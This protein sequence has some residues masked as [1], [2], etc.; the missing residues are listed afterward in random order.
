MRMIER[1]ASFSACSTAVHGDARNRAVENRHPWLAPQLPGAPQLT[2][3]DYRESR[4]RISYQPHSRIAAGEVDERFGTVLIM[5]HPPT[6]S[7]CRSSPLAL[8]LPILTDRGDVYGS[9]GPDG[10]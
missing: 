10:N 9:Q 8:R 1:K 3:A 2:T 7:W 6:I 4:L 5:P